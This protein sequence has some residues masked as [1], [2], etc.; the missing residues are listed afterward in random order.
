MKTFVEKGGKENIDTI[1]SIY[2][3]MVTEDKITRDDN[4]FINNLEDNFLLALKNP[5]LSVEQKSR[6]NRIISRVKDFL[7]QG[8]VNRTR[9]LSIS[10]K[11]EEPDN[12]EETAQNDTKRPLLGDKDESSSSTAQ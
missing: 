9:K 7:N 5:D 8:K 10:V 12:K 1:A 11:R 4:G 6:G 2:A 3:G